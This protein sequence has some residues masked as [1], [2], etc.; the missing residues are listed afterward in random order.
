MRWV[1]IALNANPD[2]EDAITDILISEGCAGT[3]TFSV[4]DAL[5]DLKI[6]GYLPVDDRLEAR[7]LI[8]KERAGRLVEYGLSLPDPEVTITWVEDDEWATAWKKYF[9]PLKLG[10]I[11]IKPTWEDYPATAD[12]LIIELDPGMAFGTGNHDTTQ[13]CVLA[14]QDYVTPGCTVLDAGC[15]SGILAMSAAKLGAGKVLAFDNDPIAVSAATSNVNKT[16][17]DDKI[18]VLLGDSPT[19]CPDKSDLVI[20]NIIPN[21]IINMA[22]ELA[23]RTA[24]GGILIVS[25]I[26]EDR[27]DD[28]RVALESIGMIFVEDRRQTVWCALV[29]RQTC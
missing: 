5:E 8:I 20:A 9:K 4:P 17:L 10:R 6:C 16:G 19:I 24:P 14:L 23:D 11:V 7:L 22:S 29:F 13:L 1:E 2:T 25:G 3:A 27:V 21:V 18:T 28:V 15:G 26:V 12:D